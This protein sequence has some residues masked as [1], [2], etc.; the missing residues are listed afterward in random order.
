LG[1]A[2][3]SGKVEPVRKERKNRASDCHF[4]HVH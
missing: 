4:L 3:A 1:E 2:G